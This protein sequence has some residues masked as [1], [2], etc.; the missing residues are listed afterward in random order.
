MQ[1]HFKGNRKWN[2]QIYCISRCLRKYLSYCRHYRF[3]S[4]LAIH[5]YQC[6]PSQSE[7]NSAMQSIMAG[8]TSEPL[9]S[10][11]TEVFDC[12]R[13]PNF[14]FMADSC[15]TVSITLNISMVGEVSYNILNCSVKSFCSM[16]KNIT[17]GALKSVVQS[18]DLE[19]A[20]C[21][22]I[23]CE[24][25]RCNGPSPVSSELASKGPSSTP[26]ARASPNSTVAPS[27]IAGP[28]STAAIKVPSNAAIFS[29]VCLIYLTITNLC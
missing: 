7:I 11:P 29:I 19:L 24:G 21:D 6:Q 2:N 13:D 23:C 18:P 1:S 22:V 28:S 17:C 16:T 20:Q 9:C 3:V 27:S 25:E 4:A 8:N 12:S 26:V 10:N 15:L 5:C 14:G